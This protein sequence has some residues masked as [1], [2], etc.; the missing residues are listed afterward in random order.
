MQ[1]VKES[2]WGREKSEMTYVGLT[3]RGRV[4]LAVTVSYGTAFAQ[5]SDNASHYSVSTTISVSGG[6]AYSRTFHPALL[7]DAT[8]A[9][10]GGRR[11]RFH[12]LGHPYDCEVDVPAGDGVLTLRHGQR[13]LQRLHETGF[14]AEFR[15]TLTSGTVTLSR[16]SL[17][18]HM[19]W[20]VEG[21]VWIG[22]A[23][24]ITVRGGSVVIDGRGEPR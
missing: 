20:A 24:G 10:N 2:R 7:V 4:F 9:S 5:S 12:E 14:R 23:P 13:C 3:W 19:E 1:S 16:Q 11:L 18:T 21:T 8:S 22:A 6:P 15:S 17:T